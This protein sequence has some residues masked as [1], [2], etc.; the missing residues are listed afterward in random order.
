MKKTSNNKTYRTSDLFIPHSLQQ[1]Q[2][3]T[4]TYR[5]ESTHKQ[6]QSQ[7]QLIKKNMYLKLKY[8]SVHFQQWI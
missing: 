6:V 1:Q 4:A 8:Q 7:T 2:K 5:S 3:K